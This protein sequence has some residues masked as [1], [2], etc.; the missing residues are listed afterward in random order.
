VQTCFLALG[1]SAYA[2]K[3]ARRPRID[4]IETEQWPW[5]PAYWGNQGE[6][7][8][9]LQRRQEL[10]FRIV[11]QALRPE[12]FHALIGPSPGANS[13]QMMQEPEDRTDLLI[14]SRDDASVLAMDTVG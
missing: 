11:G 2:G 4:C 5:Q 8:S 12:H 10:N 7:A 6:R 1:V 13:T 9:F 14:L 3:S